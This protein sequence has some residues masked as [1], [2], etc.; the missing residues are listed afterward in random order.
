MTTPKKIFV[1][2]DDHDIL[3]IIQIMLQTENYSVI[4]SNNAN[5]IFAYEKAD[6]PDLIM[7]DIWMSGLDGREICHQLKRH[8]LTKNIPVL[9]ISA[10]SNIQEIAKAYSADGFIAKPFEMSYLLNKV[11]DSLQ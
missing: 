10:N 9:F 4:T 6:L 8:E 7:L 1:A 3:S 5:D 11:H 2:D